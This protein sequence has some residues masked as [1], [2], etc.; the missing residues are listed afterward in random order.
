MCKKFHFRK[1]IKNGII[2]YF[3]STENV[4]NASPNTGEIYQSDTKS[5]CW[6]AEFSKFSASND[7]LFSPTI[8]LI[9]RCNDSPAAL[10]EMNVHPN[11][12][13]TSFVDE[14]YSNGSQP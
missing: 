13:Q 1:N 3:F 14:Q 10:C 7:L 6:A 8:G 4:K 11:L 2:V 9:E 5:G 12:G